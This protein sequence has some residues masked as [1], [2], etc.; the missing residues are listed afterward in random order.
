MLLRYS[1]E[2]GL[3]QEIHLGNVMKWDDLAEPSEERFRAW[4]LTNR[5]VIWKWVDLILSEA[6]N[7]TNNRGFLL[8]MMDTLFKKS[9]LQSFNQ[10]S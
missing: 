3:W 10:L 8:F 1:H 6:V 4:R 7:V 5:N 2:K 9:L